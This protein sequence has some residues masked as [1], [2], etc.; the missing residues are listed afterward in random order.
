[1]GLNESYDQARG[2]IL[3]MIPLP[4]L[5]K[6][7]SMLIERES[8]RRITQST[9][10]EHME[11]HAMFTARNSSLPKHKSPNVPSY[12]PSVYCD[13][14]HRTGHTRAICFQLHGYPPGLERRKKGPSYGRERNHNDK[15]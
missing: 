5:N 4:S 9:S 3:M 2:Q 14:C 8:Q 7:Y 12:D 10:S 6:A 13:Y 11:L 15:K 1:M